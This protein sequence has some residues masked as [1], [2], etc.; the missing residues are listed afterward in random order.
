MTMSVLQKSVLALIIVAQPPQ[1]S[2]AFYMPIVLWASL[3]IENQKH[4]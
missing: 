2:T 1:I 4:H 3:K